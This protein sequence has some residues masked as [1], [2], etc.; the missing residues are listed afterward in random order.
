MDSSF[1]SSFQQDQILWEN[2]NYESS[3]GDILVL[4]TWPTPST[5]SREAHTSVIMIQY[6]IHKW[7]HLRSNQDY[8]FKPLMDTL[9]LWTNYFP[10]AL[11]LVG[12]EESTHRGEESFKGLKSCNLDGNR[13]SPLPC[14][15]GHC[16]YHT[17]DW[18]L[19]WQSTWLFALFLIGNLS[20]TPTPWSPNRMACAR[21]SDTLWR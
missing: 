17:V 5:H 4:E 8:Q 1:L 20:A 21:S 3:K 6:I 14:C 9:N 12:K 2:K 18:M 13:C 11:K 10:R 15:I 16:I 7:M 19:T